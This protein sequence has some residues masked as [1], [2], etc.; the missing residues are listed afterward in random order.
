MTDKREQ[1]APDIRRFDFAVIG[2]GSGG[3]AA[4]RR[5]AKHGA[6]TVLFEFAELGGTCVNRGCVP[7]KVFWNAA[8]LADAALDAASYGFAELTPE[9]HLDRFLSRT[10]EHI[11]RLNRL[12]AENLEKEGVTLVRAFARLVAP[13]KVESDGVTYEAPHVLIAVGGRPKVP[14]LPGAEFFNVSDDFFRMTKL[15]KRVLIVGAGYVAV[16]LAGVLSH[17]GSEV[18]LAFRGDT[19]LRGFDS[20]IQQSLLAELE[21]TIRIEK[22]FEVFGVERGATGQ[23]RVLGSRAIENFDYGIWAVGRVPE[24]TALG[25]VPGSRDGGLGELGIAVDISGRVVVDEYQNTTQAGV[26]AVG[27]VTGRATLTPVAIAEG[28]RLSDR[29]FGGVERPGIDYELVPTVVFSHPPVGRVGL[30]SEEAIARYGQRVK[31]YQTRFNDTYYT[32]AR[33]KVPTTM[34]IVCVDSEERVIGMHVF[35]RGADEMIQGFSVAVQMG[36]TKADLDRTVAIHP[37]ASEEF[38]TMR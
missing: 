12:Y 14:E 11:R 22:N 18:S 27:D 16:E 37:T 3:L 7:K 19:V 30:T 28:R 35:G 32:L 23:L 24:L 38:V 6:K 15:P 36:A 10:H 2:G 1:R 9:F 13:G 21:Q 29:L 17:L 31:I 34:K 20:M 4:A 33:R 25:P 26:Y 8:N 5:A